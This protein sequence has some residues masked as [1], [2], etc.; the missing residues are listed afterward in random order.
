[1]T[2]C[3]V[4]VGGFTPKF[5]IYHFMMWLVGLWWL[6]PLSTIFQLYRCDQFYWWRK[7]EYP[8][9]TTE[10]SWVTDKLYHIM[11]YRVCLA[12]VGFELTMLVV[13]GTDYIGSCISNYHTIT[14]KTAP[15]DVKRFYFQ[16]DRNNHCHSPARFYFIS[17]YHIK[18]LYTEY[19]CHRSPRLCSVCRNHISPLLLTS[20]MQYHQIFNKS[21][22]RVPLVRQQPFSYLGRGGGGLGFCWKK[23]FN[24]LADWKK[25]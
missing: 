16:P 25:T 9:K 8:Q 21:K 24:A 17:S 22:T 13:L 15:H 5:K 7:P 11:L 4:L 19:L 3:V 14:T 20:F 1:M 12:W 10:L 23:Y 18:L 6:T 2:I